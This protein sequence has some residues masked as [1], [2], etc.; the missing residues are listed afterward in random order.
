MENNKMAPDNIVK[1]PNDNELQILPQVEEIGILAQKLHRLVSNILEQ[2]DDVKH[3]KSLIQN[4]ENK[5]ITLKNNTIDYSI[6][7]EMLAN[8]FDRSVEIEPAPVDDDKERIFWGPDDMAEL[9]DQIVDEVVDRLRPPTP[10]V[11]EKVVQ[12]P[13]RKT[14]N[15]RKPTKDSRRPAKTVVENK[16]SVKKKENQRN[17]DYLGIGSKVYYH[18]H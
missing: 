1:A 9:K 17:K 6:D 12:E 18:T 2:P 5:I 4:L 10:P 7:D 14:V 11:P 15:T 13:V 16:V 3:V 8:K